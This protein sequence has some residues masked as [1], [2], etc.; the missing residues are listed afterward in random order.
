MFDVLCPCYSSLRPTKQG[1]YF[2]EKILSNFESNCILLYVEY[3]S[4]EIGS[5]QKGEVWSTEKR[6]AMQNAVFLAICLTI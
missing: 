6:V 2:A 3:N 1:L 4:E 5:E